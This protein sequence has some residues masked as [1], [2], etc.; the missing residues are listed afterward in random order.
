MSVHTVELPVTLDAVD[1]VGGRG[2]EGPCAT[3]S[4][5]YLEIIAEARAQEKAE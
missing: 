4:L 2:T 1:P 3:E 5:S